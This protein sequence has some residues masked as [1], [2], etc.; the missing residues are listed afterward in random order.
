MLTAQWQDKQFTVHD[1]FNIFYNHVSVDDQYMC[2]YTD[3]F[4]RIHIGIMFNK[5]LCDVIMT[6]ESTPV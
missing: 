4:N 1:C 5:I 3:L 6:F 2:D